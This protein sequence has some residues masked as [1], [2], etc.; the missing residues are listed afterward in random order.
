VNDDVSDGV[1][2]M[3]LVVNV[4]CVDWMM[5]WIGCISRELHLSNYSGYLYIV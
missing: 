4:S 3:S 5:S 2:K 1:E